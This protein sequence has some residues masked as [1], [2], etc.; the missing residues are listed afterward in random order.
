MDALSEL[1]PNYT[2][3]RYGF[4]NP[5]YWTDPTGLFEDPNA[6]RAFALERGFKSYDIYKHEDK[7]YVLMVTEGEF[8]GYQFY[9]GQEF[10]D[11]TELEELVITGSGGSNASVGSFLPSYAFVGFTPTEIGQVASAG[12][13]Y[14]GALEPYAKANANY[15][16]KYAS[17]THSAEQLTKMNKARMTRIA[18]RA[19]RVGRGLTGV[20]VIATI[21]DGSINGWQNHH[22]ADL[23]ITGGLYLLAASNPAGWIIGGVY[24]IADVAVQS[25]TGK[26]I[27]ENLFD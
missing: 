16:Y 17:K 27:T 9:Y 22:T 21:A 3:Y 23:V 13:A 14:T 4:N 11:E 15:Q 20:A 8:D 6:A 7:G 19:N 12:G 26:S 10:I 1:A 24:F 2:P 5:V 25:H 18:K